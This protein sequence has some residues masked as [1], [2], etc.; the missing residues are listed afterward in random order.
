MVAFH[1]CIDD[2]L[3]RDSAAHTGRNP[4]PT[5]GRQPWASNSTV[6]AREA[7]GRRL[8]PGSSADSLSS[9][10]AGSAK[11]GV[12][13]MRPIQRRIGFEALYSSALKLAQ[14]WCDEAS[15]WA[16]SGTDPLNLQDRTARSGLAL[17]IRWT[18]SD[19]LVRNRSRTSPTPADASSDV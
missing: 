15:R 9:L 1:C 2:L 16:R 13:A 4:D 11:E 17:P 18:R 7:W 19:N 10:G 3:E 14:P 8:G 12:P 6:R 5:A